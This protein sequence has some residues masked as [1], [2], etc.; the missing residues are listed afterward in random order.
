MS[1]PAGL[2]L[3]GFV[4]TYAKQVTAE[5][6]ALRRVRCTGLRR[7]PVGSSHK[8]VSKVKIYIA[9]AITDNPN[10]REQ[11]KRAEEYLKS[12]GHAVINPVKNEG[13]TYREYINMGLCELMQCDAIYLLKGYE[14][15]TGATLEH[16]YARTV[17]LK[18]YY[19]GVEALDWEKAVENVCTCRFVALSAAPFC[20]PQYNSLLRRY[21]SGERTKELYEA[22]MEVH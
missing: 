8:E 5:G 1:I 16:D 6:V 15:S 22:M 14:N 2:V 19:E 20:L 10:Y 13:F 12:A 4:T 17:G 18:V 3:N 11:F 21:N 7:E 9:G